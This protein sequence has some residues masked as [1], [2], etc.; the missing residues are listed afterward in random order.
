MI[1]LIGNSGLLGQEIEL[2][3][4]EEK[5]PYIGTASQVNITNLDNLEKFAMDKNID[6]IINCAAYTA[7]DNAEKDSHNA[8]NLNCHAVM[9]ITQIVKKKDAKI[10]HIST[11][12]VFDGTKTDK[13]VEEDIPNPINI[14]GKSKYAGELALTWEKRFILRTSWLFG[15]NRA[16]FVK[17][18]LNLFKTKKQLKVINDQFGLPTYTKDLVEI[19]KNIILKKSTEY[20]IYH[21]CNNGDKISWFDFASEIYKQAKEL[22]LITQDVEIL[23]ISTSEYKQTALRPHSSCLSTNKIEKKLE[24]LIRHWKIALKHFLENEML[25]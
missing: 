20:G 9:N 2:M 3:L 6:W 4:K 13:Y 25:H 22:K 14:Y 17:T 5:L 10:I 8:F 15:H 16:N 12:Y 18:M 7:V 24:I 11:D 23:P 19:I 21:C 1:W